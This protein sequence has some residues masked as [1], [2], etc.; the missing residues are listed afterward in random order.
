MRR[1]LRRLDLH[2][3]DPASVDVDA[4]VAAEPRPAPPGRP[5]VLANMVASV[6]GAIEVDGV[7][8]P[9]GSPADRAVFSALRAVAD[10]ILVGAPTATVER[11]RRHRPTAAQ[12][13]ARIARGQAPAA[14]VAV[15]SSRADVDLS[16]PVLADPDP[17]APPVVLVGAAA[18]AARRAAAAEVAE[19]VEA[20]VERVDLATALAELG[21][22]GASVVLLEGGP[23]LN[24]VLV[25]GDL[26]DEWNLTV[27]PALVGGSSPRAVAGAGPGRLGALR[28]DRVLAADDGTLLLRYVRR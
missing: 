3:D 14:R 18:P 19:V 13:T 4:L 1:V 8:G 2:A 7:S 16:L 5:W 22:R 25:D 6:D 9:L 24:A 21:R 10:V 23:R 26:V 28:L 20:G 17:E 27:S 11:Y 15:V 12:R